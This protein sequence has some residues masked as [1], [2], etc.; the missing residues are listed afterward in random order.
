M[1]PQA[2]NNVN[3]PTVL[4]TLISCLAAIILAITGLLALLWKIYSSIQENTRLTRATGSTVQATLTEQD[5]KIDSGTREA[6]AKAKQAAIQ[7]AAVALT[8]VKKDIAGIAETINGHTDKRVEDAENAAFI[9]GQQA[10]MDAKIVEIQ[11]WQHDH[12]QADEKNMQEI[13]E[14]NESHL[15]E[16]KEMQTAL[17]TVIDLL[18]ER[19]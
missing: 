7:V 8:D 12:A 11:Q 13:R 5:A 15:A 18:R 1:D 19:K 4:T 6:E 3:W 10:A 17:G 16:M 2:A 14:V 9:K